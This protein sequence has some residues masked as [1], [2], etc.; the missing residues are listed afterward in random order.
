[1]KHLKNIGLAFLLSIVSLIVLF[2]ICGIMIGTFVLASTYL[3]PEIGLGVTLFL[4]LFISAIFFVY[5]NESIKP[6]KR[7][8]RK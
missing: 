2:T 7:K 1:M 5:D 6:K 3:N 4:I 8:R